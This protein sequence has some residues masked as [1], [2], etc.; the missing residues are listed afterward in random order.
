VLVKKEASRDLKSR[1]LLLF[2]T[3]KEATKHT[4]SSIA[5]ELGEMVKEMLKIFNTIQPLLACL[6]MPLAFERGRN[7]RRTGRL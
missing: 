1:E 5:K 2:H 7:G 3:N 6:E 4:A